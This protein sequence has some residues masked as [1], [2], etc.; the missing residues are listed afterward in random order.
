MKDKK[1]LRLAVCTTYPAEDTVIIRLININHFCVKNNIRMVVC[2]TSAGFITDAYNPGAEMRVFYNINYAD[3]DAV[4]CFSE[5]IKDEDALEYIVN[6]CKEA[7]V[8][9]FML[10]RHVDGGID[11][12][13]DY[14]SA[15]EE[16]CR[17]VIE[18]KGAKKVNFLGGM[19]D[20]EFSLERENI[21]KKV[22]SENNIPFEKERIYYGHFWENPTI[23]AMDEMLAADELPDA[24]I[25]ANDLM[26]IVACDKLKEKGLK[27]PDDIMVTGFDGIER[28]KWYEPELTTCTLDEVYF[29]EQLIDMVLEYVE[30]KNVQ[31]KYIFHYTFMPSEST[32]SNEIVHRLSSERMFSLYNR[33]KNVMYHQ[34]NMYEMQEEITNAKDLLEVREVLFKHILS[35]SVIAVDHSIEEFRENV[36]VNEALYKDRKDLFHIIF[37]GWE[38]SDKDN[39]L[40]GSTELFSDYEDHMSGDKPLLMMPIHFSNQ[41]YG[42]MINELI[43]EP[44]FFT[45]IVMLNYALGN[46]FGVYKTKKSLVKANDKLEQANRELAELYIKDHLTRLYNRRGF[47]NSVGNLINE[48]ILN[49]WEIF[50]ISIDMDDL[51][52]INDNYGHSEGD[53]ALKTFGGAMMASASEYDIC[54]RFGGDEFIVAGI[55]KDGRERGTQYISDVEKRLSE[56]NNTDDKPYK[57]RGSIGLSVAKAEPDM[58]IDDIMLIAD[59]FMYENKKER[60]KFRGK[61][62]TSPTDLGKKNEG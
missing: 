47:Y 21:Y 54:A 19:P 61:V 28:A 38:N 36:P 12:C 32:G 51:K 15:F 20:N 62:R 42:Y 44:V 34:M 43:C 55:A 46:A 16:L 57:V 59:R 40:C 45:K 30:G 7:S 58:V 13:F 27:I 22:L 6:E 8:P 24:I 56:F 52:V 1:K 14:S 5:L 3:F 37:Q 29:A 48:A 17:H 41:I 31:K 53:V 50:V 39:R 49:N 11:I 60:K 10:E 4:L 18:T 35:N 25:C 26:A 23:K 2:S 33:N 9:V